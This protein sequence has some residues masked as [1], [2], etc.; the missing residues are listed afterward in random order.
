MERQLRRQVKSRILGITGFFVLVAA[1]IIGRLFS[2]QVAGHQRLSARAAEQLT[3]E[4]QFLP[5]RGIISDREDKYLFQINGRT[6]NNRMGTGADNERAIGSRAGPA[7]RAP[8]ISYFDRAA[9][10]RR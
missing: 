9:R 4:I 10:R 5:K 3:E 8:R 1:A 6:M 2:L 7:T